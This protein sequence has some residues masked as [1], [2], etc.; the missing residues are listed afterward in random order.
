MKEIIPSLGIYKNI[1]AKIIY[2]YEEQ[3]NNAIQFVGRN[4]ISSNY[5]FRTQFNRPNSYDR[6]LRGVF[7]KLL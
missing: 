7:Y 1:I 6:F 2:C 4:T 3:L 5:I